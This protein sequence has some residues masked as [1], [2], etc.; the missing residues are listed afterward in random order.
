MTLVMNQLLDSKLIEDGD[1]E[2]KASTTSTKE[3]E[4]ETM[5][6]WNSISF[7]DVEEEKN[8]GYKDV[9]ETN[10]TTRSQGSVKEDSLILQKSKRYRKMLR[11]FKIIPRLRKFPTSQDPR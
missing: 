7:F 10:V 4:E 9:M 3:Q 11:N 8:W 5:V 6:L 2:I 1:E